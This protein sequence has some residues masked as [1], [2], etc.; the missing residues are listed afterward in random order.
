MKCE[1][2]NLRPPVI[3]DYGDALALIQRGRPLR[4]E[5]NITPLTGRR[6]RDNLVA[7]TISSRRLEAI[8]V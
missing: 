6:R 3:R 4:D 2:S 5:P 1:A 8:P 7:A